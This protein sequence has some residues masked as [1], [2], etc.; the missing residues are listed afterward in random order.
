VAPAFSA[1]GLAN[2]AG[3][4]HSLSMQSHEVLREVFQ[5]CSPKQVSS[6]LGLSLSMIYKWAEPPDQAA[7]SGSANPLDRIDALLRCTQDRRLVQW[8]CQRAGGF[9]IL[10]PKTNKPH[11]D[12]LIPAT[13]EIVQEFADLLA[14]IA[15]AA[16]DNQITERESK[17][18]RVRWEELKSV[19]EGFVTC[20]E[21]G[22]FRPLK[23]VKPPASSQT[24]P[25]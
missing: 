23:E 20:C 8:I 24:A 3:L 18:I 12:F 2:R 10:N 25:G 13:N 7:G 15:A 4:F 11:P 21:E 14:V 1:F 16:A 5:Q 19:T 17:Q 6:Q 22:N 9:F